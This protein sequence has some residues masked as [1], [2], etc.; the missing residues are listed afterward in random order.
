MKKPTHCIVQQPAAKQVTLHK[1]R[2]LFPKGKKAQ[3][4]MFESVAILVVFFF[5][6]AFGATIWYGAQK[7]SFAHDLAQ[8]L[9]DNALAIVLRASHAPEL[10]CSLLG[11]QRQECIDITKA[12]QFANITQQE[13]A[14]LSYFELFGF[15]TIVLNQMYP[16]N[17]SIRLYSNSLPNATDIH[18]AYLPILIENPSQNTFSFGILEVHTYAAP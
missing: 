5:L 3:I 14:R 17:L 2:M 1:S 10:D 7:T 11:V 13:Q 4:Q 8:T 12:A 6:V 9:E 18:A 15:S 16:G